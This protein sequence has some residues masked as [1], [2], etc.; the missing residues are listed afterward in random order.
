MLVL[1]GVNVGDLELN[2]IDFTQMALKLHLI[3]RLINFDLSLQLGNPLI[4]LLENRSWFVR[5]KKSTFNFI[6]S[7]CMSVHSTTEGEKNLT[8]FRRACDCR[9]HELIH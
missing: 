8:I 4:D 6:Q 7:C 9:L 1:N 2:I 3:T 5:L